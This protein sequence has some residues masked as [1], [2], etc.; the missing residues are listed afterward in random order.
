MPKPRSALAAGAG[1]AIIAA[2]S[3]GLTAPIIA[4]A[5]RGV[6]ALSTAAL[7]YAGACVSALA[8]GRLSRSSGA[9]LQRQHLGRLM[10]IAVL[11]AGVAPTLLAWG[12]QRVGAI[13]GSLLLNLEAAFTVALASAIHHEPIGRR[14]LLALALIGLGGV[15]LTGQAVLD[16]ASSWSLLG[17][18]ALVGATFA[19]ALDNTL[20][21]PLADYDPIAV[22]AAKGALGVLLTAGLARL[23]SAPLP[24]LGPA[25]TIFACGA[26]GFGLSLRLYLLAQRRLGVARTGSIFAIAPFVGAATAWVLGDAPPGAWALVATVLFAAGITLHLTERHAHAHIHLAVE[27]DHPHR[28]DDGHHDHLHAPPFSGEHSH[29]HAHPRLD[30][31]HPHVPDLHHA[32]AHA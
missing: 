24:P 6:G 26:T 16:T 18:T 29:R 19:W 23:Q 10:A 30:H 5:G 12:L 3:F 28:H 25:L 31:D 14:V 1:F 15:A 2:L 13:K 22:V 11:G 7:L 21:R 27:H 17:T 20:M 8:L 9:R 32:H 4:R